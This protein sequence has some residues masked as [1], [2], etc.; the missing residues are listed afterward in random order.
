[1][2]PLILGRSKASEIILL[3]EK[4]TAQEAYQYHFVS[5]VFKLSEL[6]S[7][8][9]PKIREY[10]KFPPNSMRESKRLVKKA[11]HDNLI[12][13]R[14]AECEILSTR[15]YDSEFIQAIFDFGMR[16]SSKL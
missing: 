5:R 10:S 4:L 2:F 9:W 3:N 16:K 15:Y 7:V 11:L 13:A 8:I 14:D 1:M 12:R 6:D